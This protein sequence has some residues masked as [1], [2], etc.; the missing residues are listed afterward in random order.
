MKKRFIIP[1][2]G[3]LLCLT[4]GGGVYAFLSDKAETISNKFTVGNIETQIVENFPS[5]QKINKK[6]T[7]DQIISK[8]VRIKNVGNDPCYV[9]VTVGF[10]NDAVGASLTGINKTD[11][12][13]TDDDDYYYYKRIL[14]P[15]ETTSA[16]FTGVKIPP[17]ADKQLGKTESDALKIDVYEESVQVEH[18]GVYFMNYNAAWDFYTTFR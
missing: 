15:G 9:R 2:A 8:T 11:W 14:Q 5:G 10:N 12:V 6:S 13:K 1:I 4:L 16:L 18:A 17:L 3:V 7:D